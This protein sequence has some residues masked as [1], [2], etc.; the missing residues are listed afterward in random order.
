MIS[1]LGPEIPV[2]VK[3]FDCLNHSPPPRHNWDST[4]GS[5]RGKVSLGPSDRDVADRPTTTTTQIMDETRYE[6]LSAYQ[7]KKKKKKKLGRL[8]I[9]FVV[10]IDSGQKWPVKSPQSVTY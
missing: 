6:D 10:R 3:W 7:N 1:Y 9:R 5:D 2:S 4:K 8:V